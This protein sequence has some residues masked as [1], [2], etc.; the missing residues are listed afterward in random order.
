MTKIGTVPQI[1]AV[2][3]QLDRLQQQD[4]IRAWEL[5]YEELLTRLSAAVFFLTPAPGSDPG[6]IAEALA[7]DKKPVWRPNA[8]KMLSQLE[9]RLEFKE[10]PV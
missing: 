5:P 4:L 9:W 1:I 2:K 6:R 7:V 3:E 8:E 10:A